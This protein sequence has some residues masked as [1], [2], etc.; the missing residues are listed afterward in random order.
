[1]YDESLPFPRW[2]LTVATHHCVDVIRKRQAESRLFAPPEAAPLEAREPAPSA[3]SLTILEEGRQKV[4][5]AIAALPDSY[6]VPL[7]LRYYSEMSYDEIAAELGLKRA[8]VATLIFR[9]KQQL[10]TGLGAGRKA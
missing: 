7:V 9:A 10:R 3:L 8:H 5:D 4:R 6:R 1:S 2:L